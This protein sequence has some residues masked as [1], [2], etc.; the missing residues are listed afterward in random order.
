MACPSFEVRQ[1][2][3][4]PERYCKIWPALFR[5]QDSLPQ[6]STEV[7]GRNDQVWKIRIQFDRSTVRLQ[8]E[9]SSRKIISSSRT[10]EETRVERGPEESLSAT[11][12]VEGGQVLRAAMEQAPTQDRER[13]KIKRE[14]LA[15][16]GVNMFALATKSYSKRPKW[17]FS[18]A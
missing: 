3:S 10:P 15:L 1:R 8:C 4:P 7:S 13:P 16:A 14:F 17:S 6:S 18:A 12:G 9:R 11:E 2:E 5:G